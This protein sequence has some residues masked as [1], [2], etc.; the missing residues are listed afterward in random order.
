MS[1][2]QMLHLASAQGSVSRSW[3][4]PAH[5]INSGTRSTNVVSDARHD[6]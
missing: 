6:A 5:V 3:L 2:L 1:G 4:T